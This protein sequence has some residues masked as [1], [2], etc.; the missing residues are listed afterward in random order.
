MYVCG[1]EFF[2]VLPMRLDYGHSLHRENCECCR[3]ISLA[4]GLGDRLV[5]RL[6]LGEALHDVGTVR[7]K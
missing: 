5:S 2:S 7:L 3:Q 6:E 1:F 4:D